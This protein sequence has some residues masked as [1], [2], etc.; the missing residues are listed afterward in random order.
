M[1][2]LKIKDGFQ[3][4]MQINV[5]R[6]ILIRKLRKQAFAG[7]L[8]ITHIGYFPKAKYHYRER[9]LGCADNILL[10]CVDGRGHYQTDEGSFVL[11]AQQFVILPPG[12]FHMYQ[13][14]IH[15][16]WTIYWI[17][18]S[19]EKLHDLN[20]WLHTERYIVPT[21]IEYDKQIIELWSEIY[22]ALENG[23]SDNN[24]A[25]ANLCLYRFL[26]FFLCSHVNNPMETKEDP[27]AA[28]ISHMKS[29]I[30]KTLT[31]E[32]LA[33]RLGY[34]SSHYSSMFRDKTGSSPLDYFIRLKLH[35]ACQL[36]SQT[37]LSIQTISEK[38][39]YEDQF[40][41]S[42]LF[43]KIHGKSPRNYRNALRGK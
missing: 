32:E 37:D 34:S 23:Y 13:A 30:S 9:P 18:F 19:G 21:S 7:N 27:V 36:L 11:N 43:K 2:V 16:P 42:R 25:Y 35:Y 10:Y 26:T 1:A 28:S 29:Q 8:F 17:H 6:E 3:G 38:I 15:D 24:L 41:F 14:D 40:Y 4:E 31:V 22:Y 12:K 33:S 20:K 39:G 5:P